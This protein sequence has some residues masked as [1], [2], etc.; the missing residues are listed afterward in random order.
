[1]ELKQR[2]DFNGRIANVA[3][4]AN[5]ENLPTNMMITIVSKGKEGIDEYFAQK[6]DKPVQ[7]H[8]SLLDEFQL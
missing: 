5:E 8:K 4:L 3:K 6:R 2:E 1:M 7:V